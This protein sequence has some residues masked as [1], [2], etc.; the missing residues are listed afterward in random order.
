M[1]RRA[2]RHST[3][4]VR[5]PTTS[6]LSSTSSTANTQTHTR[7]LWLFRE[8]FWVSVCQTQTLS[9]LFVY[10]AVCNC[11]TPSIR[12]LTAQPSLQYWDH[13]T[14]HQVSITH[15]TLSCHFVG[16]KEYDFVGQ[17]KSIHFYFHPEDQWKG[18]QVCKV[19]SDHTNEAGTAFSPFYNCLTGDNHL[20]VSGS[21][22]WT[23]LFPTAL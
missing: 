11:L 16:F 4:T 7:V 13:F 3:D 15:F 12:A 21:G 18:L 23:A 20:A 1:E 2:S 17:L 14:L 19:T 22:S 5:V 6:L 9:L 8:W 10:F